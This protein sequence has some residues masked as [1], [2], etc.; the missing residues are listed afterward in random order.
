[1]GG[2]TRG[3][4]DTHVLSKDT[5]ILTTPR[6]ALLSVPAPSQGP[7]RAPTCRVGSDWVVQAGVDTDLC[8]AYG[9]LSG[10]RGP[11]PAPEFNNLA[12]GVYLP[13][14]CVQSKWAQ[15]SPPGPF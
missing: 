15:Y 9:R 7:F 5:H 12:V 14:T 1:M 6:T 3:V 4:K 13:S 10:V 11:V 2:R 8:A